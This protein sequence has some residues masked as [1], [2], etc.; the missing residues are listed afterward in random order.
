MN[1]K[2]NLL[3]APAAPLLLPA[4]ASKPRLFSPRV[5]RRLRALVRLGTDIPSGPALALPARAGAPETSGFAWEDPRFAALPGEAKAQFAEAARGMLSS[6]IGML[7][8]RRT[9]AGAGQHE[10]YNFL[11]TMRRIAA[12]LQ[13]DPLP[14]PSPAFDLLAGTLADRQLARQE[15]KAQYDREQGAVLHRL[16]LDLLGLDVPCPS[17]FVDA[18]AWRYSLRRVIGWTEPGLCV[19]RRMPEGHRPMWLRRTDPFSAREAQAARRWVDWAEREYE[20]VLVM[21]QTA[22]AR[23]TART[24]ARDMSRQLGRRMK[25][26]ELTRRES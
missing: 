2:V 12:T 26:T 5:A 16:I 7:A 9:D 25:E 21:Q 20:R 1:L 3:P 17:G 14:R 6:A 23:G 24:V 22:T 4:R 8:A 13:P 10:A 15:W 19:E 18:G 11:A